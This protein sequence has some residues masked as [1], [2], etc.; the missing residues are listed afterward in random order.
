MSYELITK[1]NG[2][3]YIPAVK[4]EIDLNLERKGQPGK[5]TFEVIKDDILKIAE[6]D[7]V[8][9]KKNEKEMF[10]G[11]VFDKGISGSNP[12]Q[13][14][15]TCY[16][17]LYYLK[18]KDTYVFTGKKAS[19]IVKMIGDDFN[20]NLGSIAD[21]KYIID[22][23][24]EDGSALFDIIQ[25]ALD[26]TITATGKM[27]VL[28][29]DAGKLTLKNIA[30]MKTRLIVDI[31]TLESYDYKSSISSETYNK[32]KLIYDSDE[33]GREVYIAK[34]SKNIN[35]WGVLQYFES[36][37][38]NVGAQQ[39]AKS[40]LSLY[41]QPTKTLKLNNVLGDVSVRA[42]SLIIVKLTIDDTVLQNYMLVEQVKHKFANDSHFMDLK[43]RG[44]NFV[45]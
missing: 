26:T 19:Q 15:I 27:Y 36:I 32:V 39:R 43:V 29:D 38:S 10:Y 1:H 18:N 22:S 16:D 30:D 23:Q 11:F 7:P 8:R 20:L 24:T 35:K 42:G 4:D 17:Q 13:I 6:G 44:G 3:I 34:D 33:T 14:K 12:N 5:L 25:N 31:D 40:L 21:T 9:F 2:K 28:Y 37:N 45:S 41:D